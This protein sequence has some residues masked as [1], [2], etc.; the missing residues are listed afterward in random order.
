MRPVGI[1]APRGSRVD[2]TEIRREYGWEAG[3]KR[4]F[5]PKPKE[6]KEV[7]Q[8]IVLDEWGIEG[9]DDADDFVWSE[10]AVNFKL[11]E[12][13]RRAKEKKGE[14]QRLILGNLTNITKIIFSLTSCRRDRQKG[15]FRAG[16]GGTEI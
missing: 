14:R 3:E 2:F 6:M 10:G 16:L 11:M 7:V 5:Q 13:L 9:E 8:D 4:A 15:Q 1:D 12:E